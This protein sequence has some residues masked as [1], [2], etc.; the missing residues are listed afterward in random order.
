MNSRICEGMVIHKRYFE[1]PHQFK[2]KLFM[3][4]LDLDEL[5]YLFDDYWL[6]SHEKNN[7]ASF[8]RK[9]YL[10]NVELVKD[11]NYS[12]IKTV[13]ELIYKETK[14]I[15]D[16]VY[17]LTNLAYFGYCFNPISIYFCHYKNQLINCIIEV[18][19]TPWGESHR[20]ILEP[21]LTRKDVYMMSFKKAL[22]V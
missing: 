3:M 8:K 18:T 7:V 13:K 16:K 19:N 15:I 5:D 22:H 17:L 1:K 4:L 2:Y 11:K 14:N 6:W 9:N 10:K 20:Y 12:L 21:K